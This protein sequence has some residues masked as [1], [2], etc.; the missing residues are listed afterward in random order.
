MHQAKT[1]VC[2]ASQG[3]YG[4]STWPDEGAKSFLEKI[5]VSQTRDE[6]GTRT[7]LMRATDLGAHSSQ[8]C[9]LIALWCLLMALSLLVQANRLDPSPLLPSVGKQTQLT[10]S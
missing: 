4:S 9:L 8:G 1:Q 3:R 10:K 5:S 6:V 7:G 2:S